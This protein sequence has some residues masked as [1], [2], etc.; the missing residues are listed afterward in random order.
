MKA[1]FGPVKPVPR[2]SKLFE[3][4]GIG[5]LIVEHDRPGGGRQVAQ[6]RR[7]EPGRVGWRGDEGHADRDGRDRTDGPGGKQRAS[8]GHGWTSVSGASELEPCNGATVL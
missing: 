4:A 6:R 2:P 5:A 8:S 1:P 7:H 3:G